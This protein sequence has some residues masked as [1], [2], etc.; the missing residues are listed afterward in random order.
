[1]KNKAKVNLYQLKST[2]KYFLHLEIL[3]GNNAE[4][5]LTTEQAQVLV[6]LNPKKDFKNNAT[7]IEFI[8]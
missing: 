2:K 5:E 7:S 8:I 6:T 1:M 4:I 3:G